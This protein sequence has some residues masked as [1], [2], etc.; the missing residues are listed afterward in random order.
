MSRPLTI[1][2]LDVENCNDVIVQ[3]VPKLQ[4]NFGHTKRI[5]P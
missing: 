5:K 3:S 1:A 4:P 2:D